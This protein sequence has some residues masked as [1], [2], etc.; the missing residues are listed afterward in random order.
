MGWPKTIVP[1]V[2]LMGSVAASAQ[3]PTYNLGRTP[4]TDEIR[5]WDIAISDEGKELPPGSGT[6]DEGEKLY[7][8]KG[9][10]VCHGPNGRGG[11]APA[12][13]KKKDTDKPSGAAPMAGSHP[14]DYESGQRIMVLY[15]PFATVVWDFI[16]RAMPLQLAPGTLSADETY[17]LTAFLLYKNDVINEND[18]L[19]A[20]TL[21]KVKMPNRD[22]FI[23]PDIT[24]WKPGMLRAFTIIP[25]PVDEK[26]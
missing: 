14:P 12:L 7:V 4:N 9:C 10:V 11:R 25:P 22:G 23:P 15:A 20:Q 13:V 2:I 17:S 16:H 6:A 8:E 3:S 26:K 24:H 19:D 5:S 21:P 1:V 18:V